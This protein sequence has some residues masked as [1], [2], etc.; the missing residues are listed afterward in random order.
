MNERLRLLSQTGAV[1]LRAIDASDQEDLRRWKNANRSAFFFQGVITREQQDQWFQGYL[2][3]PND[4]MFVVLVAET[5]IGCMGFRLLEQRA[6]IYNVIRAVATSGRGR[7]GAA[8]RLMCSFI[9][10]HYTPN[11]SAKVLRDNQA[12]DWYCR[13]GFTIGSAEVSFFEVRLDAKQFQP[14]SFRLIGCLPP[15]YAIERSVH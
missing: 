15:D 13:N 5:R 4:F 2:D 7:M 14:A 3:R 9:L 11:I 6:D 12:V 8:L 10:A 1:E